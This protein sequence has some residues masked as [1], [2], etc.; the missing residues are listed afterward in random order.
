M[1]QITPAGLRI[2]GRRECSRVPG[3]TFGPERPPSGR[4]EALGLGITPG[5][6]SEGA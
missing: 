5:V 4:A 3:G 6:A 2:A 1:R